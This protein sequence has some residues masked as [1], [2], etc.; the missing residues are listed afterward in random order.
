MLLDVPAAGGQS[1]EDQL[2]VDLESSLDL[3]SDSIPLQFYMNTTKYIYIYTYVYVSV[4][5]FYVFCCGGTPNGYGLHFF[6][7]KKDQ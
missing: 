1:L 6:T 5:V 3:P 7:T 4:Y 2:Q